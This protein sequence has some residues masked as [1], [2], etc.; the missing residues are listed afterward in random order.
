MGWPQS[1]DKCDITEYDYTL[2]LER[3]GIQRCALLYFNA[4]AKVSSV[5]SS[6]S[7]Q[8]TEESLKDP[9]LP[10]QRPIQ[11]LWND[12]L[13]LHEPPKPGFANRTRCLKKYVPGLV[14]VSEVA[15]FV[16]TKILA[17]MIEAMA[18]SE[19]AEERKLFSDLYDAYVTAKALCDRTVDGDVEP[20]IIPFVLCLREQT[21]EAEEVALELGV[22]E[23]EKDPDS[24]FCGLLQVCEVG[25]REPWADMWADL[26]IRIL[27]EAE[28]EV[29]LIA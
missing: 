27:D 16:A 3:C 20:W 12:V 14:P 9:S 29:D 22:A 19:Y 13:S 25:A 23:G 11:A 17:P 4:M 24:A 15:S 6:E 5:S 2:Y 10:V 8:L 7:K 26:Q 18:S 28:Y 1:R 21:A